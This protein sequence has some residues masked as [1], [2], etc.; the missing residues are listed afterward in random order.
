[1][2]KAHQVRAI[3]TSTNFFQFMD[4]EALTKY[5]GWK[6]PRVFMRHYFKN[7]EA[8]KFFAVAAGK[9]VT[10]AQNDSE[11]EEL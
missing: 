4:F 1:M 3:A 10:P 5:T 11:E 8:L 2:P 7:I 6:S 9:V